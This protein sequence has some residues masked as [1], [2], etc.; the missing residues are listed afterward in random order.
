MILTSAQERVL[1]FLDKYAANR[2][3]SLVELDQIR[4]LEADDV[5]T[6]P[7]LIEKKLLL[8]LEAIR[9]VTLTAAGAVLADEI[10]SAQFLADRNRQQ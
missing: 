10:R 4:L 7:S 2:W 9:A 6:I 5:L 3:V 1:T 8:Y